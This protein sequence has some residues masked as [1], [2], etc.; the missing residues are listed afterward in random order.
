MQTVLKD[1]NPTWPEWVNQLPDDF[2]RQP[3]NIRPPFD[4][5]MTVTMLVDLMVRTGLATCVAGLSV[6]ASFLGISLGDILHGEYSSHSG[7]DEE[8]F[9]RPRPLPAFTVTPAHR[10]KAVVGGV[11]EKL[12]WPSV[13]EA[14]DYV[15][16][17]NND[18]A[19]AW[20]WRHGD[21]PRPTVVLV[22]GF[23]APWWEVNEY[24]LG[25]RYLFELGCDV[26]LKTLPHHGP[27]SRFAKKVSG[28]DFVT[29]GIDSLNHSVVQSTY[30]IRTLM[31]FL[32]QQGVE[33]IGMAGVSL[34]GYTTALLA[35]LDNR[36]HFA[37][38]H[39]PIVSLPDA[40]MEWTPLNSA[41]RAALRWYGA[42]VRDLRAT[43]ALHSPLSRP[44]LLTP[45]RLMIIGGMGDRLASPRHAE[46]LQQH[47]GHC[48][49]HWFAGAHAVIRQQAQINQAKKAFLESI[50][51]IDG[52]ARSTRPANE[53]AES[54]FKAVRAG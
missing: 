15:S 53:S 23:L 26:V 44:T 11:F 9:H 7:N 49:V 40:I 48:H 50:G 33:R 46:M 28:M 20:Y 18:N 25:S 16:H 38:P 27:R 30:D 4:P 29:R 41:M 17:N 13:Y 45:D 10:P 24:Y 2:Y 47:W 3:Q 31:D 22:H 42:S 32:Q 52:K 8:V 34:G 21:R 54:Q 6:P 12:L 19:V 37:I 1:L 36:L 35:G 51:F 43:M 5:A 39:L 14:N